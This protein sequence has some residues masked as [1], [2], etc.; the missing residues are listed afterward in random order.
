VNITADHIKKPKDKQMKKY[1]FIL[2][3]LLSPALCIGQ[4]IMKA[5]YFIG[6]DPGFGLATPIT[7]TSPGDDL[8]LN[9]TADLQ[10]L[11]KGFH[12]IN[13]RARDDLGRWSHT[14]Q[15]IFYVS[16]LPSGSVEEIDR[17][18]YFI[19]TDPGFG[20]ASP[21]TVTSPGNN[22]TIVFDAAIQSLSE[23]FH[24]ISVRASDD[25]GRW[26]HPTQRIFYVS[27]LP[28]GLAEEIDRLEYFID[29]DPGFGLASPVTVTSPG[30]NITIDFDAAIQSLS[31]G[32]HFISVRARDDLGRWSH[33]T[34]RIFYV[35]KLPSDSAKEI[36]NIEYFIDT[37]PGFG[38]GTPVSLATT[39]NDLTVNFDVDVSTISGGDH[40][41]YIR[42]KDD[43]GR[44]SEVYSQAFSFTITSS[45]EKELVPLFKLY[46]NPSKGNFR[47]EFS[48]K[49]NGLI[50]LDIKDM[51]GK[52][53][54]KHEY[55][56]NVN[57]INVNLPAGLY[58]LNI[59]TREISFTQKIIIE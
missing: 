17:L 18:E 54:F 23:G 21:V 44:W 55:K 12:V 43:L 31:E 7:V 48:E 42:C 15:R 16:E 59:E 4:E 10:S 41:L 5:E 1:I 40:V 32:F 47:L 19:D 9:L 57:S 14:I 11:A 56:S 46:P 3:V 49:Q 45:G 26:S 13:I 25:L 28:S 36:N 20:L 33:P 34:Q 53:V 30:N 2:F 35:F 51:N 24:F 22:I 8:T 58:L 50:K 27:E 37:D 52:T 38:N 29:T 39:G 6:S